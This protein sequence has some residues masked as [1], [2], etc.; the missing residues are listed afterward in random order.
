[1]APR[2][3]P[4]SARAGDAAAVPGA[5]WANIKPMAHR[6]IPPPLRP[7]LYRHRNL[8]ERLFNKLKH[9][10]AIATRYD[11]LPENNLASVKLA[12]TRNWMRFNESET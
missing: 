2:D 12:S 8:V 3:A 4:D 11:T 6:L 9:F 5:A 10:R 7:L 1:M